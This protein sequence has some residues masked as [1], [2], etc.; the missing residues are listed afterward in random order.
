[1][2]CIGKKSTANGMFVRKSECKLQLGR[3]RLTGEANINIDLKTL[4]WGCGVWSGFIWLRIGVSGV[5]L[6][7]YAVWNLLTA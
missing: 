5:L 6:V 7:Q 2:T 4:D 1:M 3:P